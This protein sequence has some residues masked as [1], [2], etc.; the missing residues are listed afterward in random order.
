MLSGISRLRRHPIR[1]ALWRLVPLGSAPGLVA[2]GLVGANL[3]DQASAQQPLNVP[4]ATGYELKLPTFPTQP[5]ELFLNVS[6][7][8]DTNLFGTESAAEPGHPDF[9]N[10][11]SWTTIIGP[12][13]AF[14]LLPLISPDR[15]GFLK[16]LD[17]SYEGDESLFTGWSSEDNFR[18][19]LNTQVRG[20]GGPWTL[21]VDNTLV[22]VDGPTEDPYYSTYSPLG[23]REARDRRNQVDESNYST[24]RYDGEGW[25]ARAVAEAQYYNLLIDEHNPVG[26]YKGYLNWVN[27][28]DINTGADFGIGLSKNFDFVAGWRIGQQTQARTYY[29]PGD[30][31]NTYNRA[32]F[33]FEGKLVPW[34]QLSLVAGPDWRRYGD[35]ANSGVTGDRHTWLY[36]ESSLTATLSPRDTLTFSNKVWHWVSASGVSSYQETT[37]AWN[38]RHAFTASFSGSVGLVVQGVRYDTPNVR[39]DWATSYPIDLTYSFTR[40]VSLSFDCVDNRGRSKIPVAVDP[41]RDWDQR[42]V[43]LSLRI[44]H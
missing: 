20:A 32:L 4:A 34:L 5:V 41:G 40:S 30:S 9:A 39:N 27:R 8:Y 2:L 37:S 7:G 21:L 6:E 23:Y 22:Y 11:F 44:A 19:I 25:F 18:N 33:G 3:P 15:G 14:D 38:Y 36:T 16:S 29:S 42:Q 1:A 12:K 28:D 13:I 26:A 24:L 31:D 35:G 17:V 10:I 43:F